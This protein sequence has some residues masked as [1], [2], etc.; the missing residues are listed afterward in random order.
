MD[1]APPLREGWV[2]STYLTAYDHALNTTRCSHIA[3]ALLVDD[4]LTVTFT[5]DGIRHAEICSLSTLPKDSNHK[6]VDLLIIRVKKDGTMG[7]AK[8]C[9]DC[10][11]EVKAY[12]V[13][14]VYYSD[15]E[16]EIKVERATDMVTDHLCAGHY[17]R[18]SKVLGLC[19][20]TRPKV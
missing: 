15:S 20:G 10:L 14:Y 18:E 9:F 6:Y 7:L 17:M 1:W 12:G 13:R 16:G 2:I 4:D 3:C 19:L 8:P 5:N 11:P